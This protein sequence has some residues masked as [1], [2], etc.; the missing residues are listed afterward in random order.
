MG[1]AQDAKVTIADLEDLVVDPSTELVE[2]NLQTMQISSRIREIEE[3][4]EERNH[5]I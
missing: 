4:M 1:L 2:K 5:T 3:Q